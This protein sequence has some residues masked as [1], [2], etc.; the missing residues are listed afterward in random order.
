MKL[1]AVVVYIRFLEKVKGKKLKIRGEVAR[2]I[3][4]SVMIF[5]YF[6]FPK[7]NPLILFGF[8]NLN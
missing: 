1:R 6:C 2:L 8:S 7:L 4:V 3:L 5:C